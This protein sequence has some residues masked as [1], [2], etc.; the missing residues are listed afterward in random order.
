MN[1]NIS[2]LYIVLLMLIITGCS[3]V[4]QPEGPVPLS[5]IPD[6]RL[7]VY[8]IE[9]ISDDL[10]Y[11]ELPVDSIRFFGE[12]I[13]EY[14]EIVGYD[15]VYFAFTLVEL[16]TERL[17]KINNKYLE[18]CLPF[19]V[20]SQGEVIF[21]AYLYHPLSSFFPYWYY[22]TAIRQNKFT[23]YAPVWNSRPDDPD[24]RKDPR[25]LR[26]LIEDDKIREPEFVR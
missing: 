16:A 13:L 3:E 12:R 6:D 26:I 18:W 1:R 24:P 15:T 5:Q 21:G 17:S 8:L 20:V 25:M 22:A 2:K 19:A 10:M 4:P 7:A 11:Q 9:G 23:I 14:H